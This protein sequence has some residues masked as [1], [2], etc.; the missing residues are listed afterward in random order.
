MALTESIRA[1]EFLLAEA[2][3]S[4]SREEIDIAA[5]SGDMVAG[6]LLGKVTASG[7]YAPYND[8]AADGTET[9]AAILYASVADSASVQSAVGVARHA[10]VIGSMLTGNDANGTADL[11]ALDILVR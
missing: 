5:S 10:E 1:G 2:N 8:G 3:G 7:E 6:T 4:I 9:A 11:A